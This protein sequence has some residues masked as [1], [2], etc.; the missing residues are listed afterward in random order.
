MIEKE[1]VAKGWAWFQ[2]GLGTTVQFLLGAGLV[3]L[4]SKL[5][6]DGAV[7]VAGRLGIPSIVIGLT[8]VA[9]GTSL[10][11]LITA[12]TSSRRAV[13]DLAVGNVLGANIANLTLVIGAAAMIQTVHMDRLTQIFNFPAMLAVML[14]ALWVLLTDRRITRREGAL[15]LAAYG[16]YLAALVT[17]TIC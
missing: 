3:V 5:L 14:L 16:A 17:L 11:E 12:V 6:V 2:T 4:G 1:Q 7:G 13:S 10:P 15:L 8:V 9:V